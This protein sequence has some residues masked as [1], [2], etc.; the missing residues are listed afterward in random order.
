[1]TGAAASATGGGGPV[2][3]TLQVNVDGSGKDARQVAEE[4]IELAE[5]RLVL[6]LERFANPSPAAA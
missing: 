1:M 3:L 6:A 2:Q 4:V 5:T